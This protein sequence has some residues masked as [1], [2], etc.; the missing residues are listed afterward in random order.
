MCNTV[1]RK[2]MLPAE[3]GGVA[4]MCACVV[5]QCTCKHVLLYKDGKGCM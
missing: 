5:H 3:Y 1:L 4:Y 2:N